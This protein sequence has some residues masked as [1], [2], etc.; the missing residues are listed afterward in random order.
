MYDKRK[1]KL[2]DELKDKEYR[3]AFVSEHIDTGIPFQI[4]A[5]RKQ[6]RWSQEEFAQNA[7]KQQEAISRVE[8]PNYRSF[9]LATLKE[10]ASVFDVALIVR[11][12][13]ISD[14]VKWELNLSSDSL[15]A[16]S[17]DHD[18]YFKEQPEEEPSLKQYTS[19]NPSSA[20]EANIEDISGTASPSPS[21][22][23]LRPLEAITDNQ[24]Y[25][26]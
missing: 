12:A 20:T 21:V 11:F 5:L 9:T 2:I 14:L 16:V 6:R 10:I 22:V 17:F 4:R 25:V 15:K 18:P 23:P 3:D 24:I 19:I 26:Q 1:E 8:N 13:P 7:G